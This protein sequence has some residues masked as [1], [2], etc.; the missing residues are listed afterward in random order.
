[1]KKNRL[2]K[3]HNSADYYRAGDAIDHLSA[4]R[5][6]LK[7][8]I[9]S[10]HLWLHAAYRD[11][12]MRYV[13]SKLGPLWIT[14]SMGVF[15]G[16]FSIIGAAL[17]GV[18][19]SD[20]LPFLTISIILWTFISSCILE[21]SDVFVSH[22]HIILDQRTPYLALVFRVLLRSFIV[23]VHN[24][25]I[26]VIVWF[27]FP[28]PIDWS[29]IYSFFGL[30]ALGVFL[31]G[32]TLAIGVLAT[33]YRDIPQLTASVIQVCFFLTPVMWDPQII[34]K[35]GR[36]YIVDLNPFYHFLEVIRNPFLGKTITM[37]NWLVAYST[38]VLA[39]ILGTMLFVRYRK[40]L[41]YWL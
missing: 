22:S 4:S 39:L 5:G 32:L 30:L 26:F 11:I 21:G 28:T 2:E 14:I 41:A 16:C 8:S 33:K 9:D 23:F 35:A 10:K 7:R 37:E 17:F 31:T 3:S 38:A 25:L 27:I 19:V 24:F 1:M 34:M 15:I 36:R 13:N 18:N 40:R 20:Y 12:F 29:I 6:D